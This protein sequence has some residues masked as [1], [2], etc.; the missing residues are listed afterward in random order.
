MGLVLVAF[1]AWAL[2]KK[3]DT[4]EFV[5]TVIIAGMVGVLF[6]WWG[7]KLLKEGYKNIPGELK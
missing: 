6:V 1:G 2:E 4:L 3:I 7:A 5:F